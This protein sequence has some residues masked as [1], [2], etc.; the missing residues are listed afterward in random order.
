MEVYRNVPFHTQAEI[1]DKVDRECRKTAQLTRIIVFFILVVPFIIEMVSF[2]VAWI[3]YILSAISALTGVCKI[4]KAIG[5]FKPSDNEKAEAEKEQIMAHYYYHCERN[6]ATFE[7]LKMENYERE[8][9]ADTQNEAKRLGV[10][11]KAEK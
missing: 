5:W 6:P 4:C 9:V 2:S 11:I 10:T 7:R 3:G 1:D 8:A